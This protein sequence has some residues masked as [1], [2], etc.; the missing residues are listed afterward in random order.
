MALAACPRRGM[1]CSRLIPFRPLFYAR[2]W[3]CLMFEAFHMAAIPQSGLLAQVRLFWLGVG[4]SCP[5]LTKHCSPRLRRLPALPPLVSLQASVL[6]FCWGS[7]CRACNLFLKTV[8]SFSGCLI[9]S[10]SIQKLF[11][12]VFSALKCSFEEFVREKVVSPSYS[13]AILGPPLSLVF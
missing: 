6:L 8:I 13:S 5:V 11:C 3:R 4:R 7:Y 12:G 2:S 1:V 10:A 9:S